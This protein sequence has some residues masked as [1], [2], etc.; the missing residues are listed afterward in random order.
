MPR[1]NP[2]S[3]RYDLAS[4]DQREPLARQAVYSARLPG[5]RAGAPLV[6]FQ[7]A[8]TGGAAACC[9]QQLAEEAQR[10]AI[11]AVVPVALWLAFV[12][13]C[14][15]SRTT[16]AA[17]VVLSRLAVKRAGAARR[18]EALRK[19]AVEMARLLEREG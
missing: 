8:A 5:D 17:Q 4:F 15:A 16:G 6:R 9:A 1:K 3:R 10:G 14:A 18:K 12:A 11:V 7:P 2:T 13:Y 19:E